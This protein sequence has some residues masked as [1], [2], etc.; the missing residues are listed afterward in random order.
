MTDTVDQLSNVVQEIRTLRA[1][2]D[3]A[4]REQADLINELMKQEEKLVAAERTIVELRNADDILDGTDEAW[5]IRRQAE[6]HF[7]RHLAR[8]T[9]V[10]IRSG[11][12]VLV[13][14]RGDEKP[15]GSLL[16]QAVKEARAKRG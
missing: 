7:V 13:T 14:V 2:A 3:T 16:R 5:L 1:A 4:R 11:G 15:K 6:I 12:R 9:R 8:G 10:K